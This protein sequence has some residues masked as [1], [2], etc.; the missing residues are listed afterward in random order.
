MSKGDDA[1]RAL[2]AHLAG[3]E[4]P[5]GARLAPER[6]L[7][8]RLNIS[9]RALREAL[10]RLELEGR[11]WRGIGQGT[12]LGPRPPEEPARALPASPPTDIMEA[13]L[14][15]EPQLAG[16]A[17]TKARSEHLAAIEQAVRRGAETADLQ[18]WG[19]WDAAFHRAVAQAAQNPLLLGLFD[20]LQACR[21]RAEW[22]RL[23]ANAATE[24]IR[25]RSVAEH[26]RIQEAIA[27]RDPAEAHAAMWDHLQSITAMVREA[28]R[29]G[30]G[31][32]G[33]TAAPAEDPERP[34]A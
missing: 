28:L 20:Q 3:L 15:L 5:E 1:L 17:A 32:S 16:L 9:R 7:S 8:A 22:G 29:A 27:G 26:R 11:I 24:A 14:A 19:R 4:L 31:W 25:R 21:A 12:F 13:R 6:E 33:A 18:S 23:R 10:S 2:R 34:A 30:H